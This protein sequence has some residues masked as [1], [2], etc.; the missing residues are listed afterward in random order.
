VVIAD[1]SV[2]IRAMRIETSNERKV[3]DSLLQSND[4]VMI[5]PVMGEILQGSRNAGEYDRLRS[6]LSALP[7]IETTRNIWSRSGEISYQLYRIG[8]PVALL[9][10]VIAALALEYNQ[11]L[12]TLDEHFGRIPGLELYSPSPTD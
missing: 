3:L 4:V 11:P 6:R 10:I 12:Y 7:F 8:T 2:W 5:G 9:D 1:T